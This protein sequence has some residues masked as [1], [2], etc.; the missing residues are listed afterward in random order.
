MRLERS[1]DDRGR[2]EDP[3]TARGRDSI[4]SAQTDLGPVLQRMLDEY[5]VSAQVR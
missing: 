5:C 4:G 3:D 2:D 1:C